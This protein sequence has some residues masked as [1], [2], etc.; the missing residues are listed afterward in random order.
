MKYRLATALLLLCASVAARAGEKPINVMNYGYG[1]T[2]CG[3]F[4]EARQQPESAERDGYAVWLGGFMT[5]V[6]IGGP[7]HNVL[8]SEDLDGALYWLEDYC[9]KHPLENFAE[10]A[11]ALVQAR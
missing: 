1:H 7:N 6:N 3:H 11:R 2:T 8:R 9:R 4:L 5:A 10:A